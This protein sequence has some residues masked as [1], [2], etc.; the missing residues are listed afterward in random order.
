M[1]MLQRI[2][3]LGFFALFLAAFFICATEA[4]GDSPTGAAPSPTDRFTFSIHSDLSPFTFEIL[5][6]QTLQNIASINVFRSTESRP[7][8]TLTNESMEPEWEGGKGLS[9]ED[10]NFDGFK[11]L[12]TV[13]W[14]GAT[15]NIG[16]NC[17]LYNTNT[18]RFVFSSE[19]SD[20]GRPTFEAE[21]KRIYSYSKGGAMVFS[22][23]TYV[24]EKD[25]LILIEQVE[26]DE[27]PRQMRGWIQRKSPVRFK[28][29]ETDPE[30]QQITRVRTKKGWKTTVKRVDMETDL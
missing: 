12:M 9:T 14:W 1:I 11:D 10:M 30:Y 24:W 18:G 7:F 29:L 16:Y 25:R 26:Q 8:Q 15:G 19:L 22:S 3:Q 21:R 13:S 28:F 5:R 2:V 23:E 20:L 6:G 4:E 27:I 17:W